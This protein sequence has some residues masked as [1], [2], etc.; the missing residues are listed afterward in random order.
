MRS[1]HIRMTAEEFDLLPRRPGW[2]HEY[3]DG[4][5]HVGPSHSVIRMALSLSP[6][7]VPCRHPIR[8]VTAANAPGLADAF[9]E[10]FVDTTEYCDWEADQVRRSAAESIQSHFDG[11]RGRPHPASRLACEPGQGPITVLGAVLVVETNRGPE[12]D[13]LFVRPGWQRRGLGTALA[14]AVVNE[15]LRADATW[16]TSTCH[17]A[18]EP[19]VRWHHRFGFV[20]EPDLYLTRCRL[21]CARHELARQRRLGSLTHAAEAVLEAECARLEN[22][23]GALEALAHD[24]RH[25][26]IA[27][28]MTVAR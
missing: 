24:D 15:L 28:I 22:E 4:H 12:L 16:L 2:K 25:E 9:Y 20:E 17:V 27:S 11:R 7:A 3:W 21:R 13:L 8:S 26:A 19:S 14:S 10:A 23:V 5:A 18:N 1:Q 6:R